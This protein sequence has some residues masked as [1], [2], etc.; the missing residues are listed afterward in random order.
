[1][2]DYLQGSSILLHGPAK[3]GKTQFCATFPKPVLFYAAEPGHRFVK[4][5]KGVVVEKMYTEKDWPNFV[6]NIASTLKRVK[7][8]TIVVDTTNTF[9]LAC[10]RYIC[11]QQR[12]NTPGDLPH[13][14][15][16]SLVY[17]E[18]LEAVSSLAS[19]AGKLDATIIFVTHTQVETLEY[20]T[21]T[22][23]RQTYVL[24]GQP[25]RAVAANVD[26]IWFMDFPTDLE[27]EACPY[28]V[29]WLKGNA[30]VRAETRDPHLKVG[31]IM[32]LKPNIGY[33]QVNRAFEKSYEKEEADGS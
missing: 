4:D 7:P 24:G 25:E 8:K 10:Q 26:N 11:K 13:G 1:M 6:K 29:M 18:F 27:K 20:R 17:N 30:E 5:M 31:R 14:K 21:C 2:T 33:K 12:I 3:V 28:R 19:E 23:K 32:K 22:I 15:G 16:W 9:Y